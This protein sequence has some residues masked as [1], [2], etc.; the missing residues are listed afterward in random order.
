[1]KAVFARFGDPELLVCDNGPPFASREFMEYCEKNDIKLLHSPP[2]NPESNGEAERN[3]QTLKN[4]MKKNMEEYDSDIFQEILSKVRNIPNVSGNLPSEL[5]FG[6]EPRTSLT[7]L[8]KTKEI[9]EDGNTEIE[10]PDN[11]KFLIG[12]KVMIKIDKTRILATIIKKI[13]DL[14]YEIRLETNGI[15]R[16][17]H[18][19]KLIKVN[20]DTKKKKNPRQK[21]R[22]T[23]DL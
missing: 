6:F 4:M 1:L 5:I 18:A 3:V 17:T 10:I 9:T 23:K 22:L 2:Y 11:R 12:E 19:N 20:T 15:I 14:I 7:K 8:V 21:K 13:T 16:I